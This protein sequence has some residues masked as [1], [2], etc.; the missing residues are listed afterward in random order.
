LKLL[1]GPGFEAWHLSPGVGVSPCDQD[2]FWE[3]NSTQK[4]GRQRE[5]KVYP[6]TSG[7]NKREIKVKN[8]SCPLS[9]KHELTI[10]YI[11]DTDE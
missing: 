11:A 1:S 8:L 7:R 9:F 3:K 6:K 2:F 5:K 4:P 10:Q